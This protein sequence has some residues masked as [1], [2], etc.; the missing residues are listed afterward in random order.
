[1][2]KD[3]NVDLVGILATEEDVQRR[4]VIVNSQNLLQFFVKLISDT[5]DGFPNA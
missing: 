1:M 4:N 2:Q 5:P 3:W